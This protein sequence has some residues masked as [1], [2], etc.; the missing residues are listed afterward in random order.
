MVTR[1]GVSIPVS[2]PGADR[3]RR[4]L[5]EV[6]QSVGGVAKAGRGL[7]LPLLGGGTPGRGFRR[8]PAEYRLVRRRRV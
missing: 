7:L 3:T 8:R 4:Q 5:R 2:A 1:G 6:G